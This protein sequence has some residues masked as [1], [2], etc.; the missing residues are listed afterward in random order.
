MRTDSIQDEQDVSSK[1][2]S[3]DLSHY[4]EMDHPEPG[5]SSTGYID[6]QSPNAKSAQSMGYT[7]MS[8]NSE[9]Y[10]EMNTQKQ[11][12][13]DMTQSSECEAYD[14]LNLAQRCP[15]EDNCYDKLDRSSDLLWES[16]ATNNYDMMDNHEHTGGSQDE[17]SSEVQMERNTHVNQENLY[18]Y[19]QNNSVLGST[20]E[21]DNVKETQYIN[22]C[23]KESE[24]TYYNN[25]EETTRLPGDL[26]DASIYTNVS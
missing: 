22:G 7:Y 14:M 21:H 23:C 16:A 24:P 20:S 11:S 10:S 4:T 18:S 25:T 8:Q 5:P 9:G 6:M 1:L 2:L 15:M 17:D 13:G 3:E 26:N 12:A 19:P